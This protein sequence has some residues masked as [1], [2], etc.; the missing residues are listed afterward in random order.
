MSGQQPAYRI[1]SKPEGSEQ[2]AE[3]AAVWKTAKPEVFSVHLNIDGHELSGIMVKNTPKPKKPA[4]PGPV[5]QPWK[6]QTPK[7]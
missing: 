1:L 6:Q 3:I 4:S 7:V 2:F 5:A